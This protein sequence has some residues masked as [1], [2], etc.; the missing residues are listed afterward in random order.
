VENLLFLFLGGSADVV[1]A[2]G[3]AAVAPPAIFAA[4][5]GASVV[6]VTSLVGCLAAGTPAPAPGTISSAAFA[7][8]GEGG[9]GCHLSGG[10]RPPS[11]SSSSSSL[12]DDEYFSVP[13]EESPY[14][15]RSR[16]SSLLRSRR[17]RRRRLRSL[18]RAARS[19]SRRC[20]ARACSRDRG[21]GGSD[22]SAFTALICKGTG[23]ISRHDNTSRTSRT[24]GSRFPL[25]NGPT[26]SMVNAQSVASSFWPVLRSMARRAGWP[27]TPAGRGPAATVIAP[28]RRGPRPRA[29]RRC[30]AASPSRGRSAGDEGSRGRT[31][32]SG[33]HP[34]GPSTRLGAS[35]AAS[36]AK[37]VTPRGARSRPCP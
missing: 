32:Q 26:G 29:S 22:R 36:G 8:L 2:A 18:L 33:R 12:P 14:C 4:H 28:M 5:T 10:A 34:P 11:L 1:T 3:A 35:P 17:S 25:T 15:T 24:R 19:C 31:P 23:K 13:G 9:E 27:H 21:V 30:E 7:A 37:A 16:N 20:T 6:R